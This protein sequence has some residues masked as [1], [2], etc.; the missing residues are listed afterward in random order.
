M[1]ASEAFPDVTE[2]STCDNASCIPIVHLLAPAEPF[3][4]PPPSAL[5]VNPDGCSSGWPLG[6]QPGR[7]SREGE[8][9]GHSSCHPLL[10]ARG[11]WTR[12]RSVPV[13]TRSRRSWRVP[14]V[15]VPSP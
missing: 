8:Y 1:S 12:G 5:A 2:L 13:S 10:L 9:A 14:F 3:P 4:P 7:R 6:V 11:A 15:T